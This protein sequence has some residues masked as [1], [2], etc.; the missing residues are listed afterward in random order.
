MVL[1]SRDTFSREAI[2]WS[3]QDDIVVSEMEFSPD[4]R[5]LILGVDTK[6]G[7]YGSH[8]L[9]FDAETLRE[10]KRIE[11]MGAPISFDFS[12]DG[13][14]MLVSAHQTGPILYDLENM[15]EIWRLE[16]FRSM[17][18]VFHPVGDRFYAVSE[19]G[20]GT[21]CSIDD[22]AEL[23]RI[24]TCSSRATCVLDVLARQ[25]PSKF[26]DAYSRRGRIIRSL[27]TTIRNFGDLRAL[28]LSRFE[29]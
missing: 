8:T 24:P 14:R 22:S 6:K 21:I 13:K 29:M 18:A 20:H 2:V 10:V 12:P 5:L 11:E 4:G 25:T 9:I 16:G 26:R 1:Y 3:S 23:V 27:P 28:Q 19:S 15:E 17:Y 7:G